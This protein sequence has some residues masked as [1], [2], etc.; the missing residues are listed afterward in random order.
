MKKTRTR[1]RWV[2]QLMK[3]GT[4]E[5]DEDLIR[6][7]LFPHDAK[8]V[9]KIRPTSRV[10]EDFIAWHYEKSGIFTVSSAYKLALQIH[11]ADQRQVG[12]SMNPD[13][14]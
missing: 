2:S 11:Q 12:S 1:L 6:T 5:W 9:L 10:E 4:R 13:G 14:S 7:Y 8:E 3:A